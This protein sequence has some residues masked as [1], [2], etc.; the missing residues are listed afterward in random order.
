M[1]SRTVISILVA[2][3]LAL[4]SMASFAQHGQQGGGADR[5]Q[6]ADRAQQADRDRAYDHDRAQDRSRTDAPDQDRDQD[7]DR[8]QDQ[9]NLK[10]QDIYGH[11]FMTSAEFDQYRK[12]FGNKNT[13]EARLAYQ[14]Q[15][16]FTMQQRAQVQG[17]DLV[18][19]G[20]G[21]VYGG[22]L[23]SVQERNEYRE[24]LRLADSD[25]KRQQ[26]EAQHKEQMQ[27]RARELNIEVE[28]A[29]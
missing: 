3:T 1:K 2:S 18:P 26:L 24:Q 20:Q 21:P 16:E 29:E 5:G 15:H 9:A 14:A 22:E 12:E 23:M 10:D 11:E 28:E 13:E 17:K 6:Q 4:A 19:P 7:Q 25:Q 8:V 27:V